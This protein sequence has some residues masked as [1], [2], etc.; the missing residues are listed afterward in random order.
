MIMQRKKL[1]LSA[2]L[3]FLSLMLLFAVL[4]AEKINAWLDYVLFILRPVLI[5]LVLAYICN[6][7]FRLFE[8]K[9]FFGVHPHKLRRILSLVVTY[10]ILLLILTTLVM[11]IVPQLIGSVLDFFNSYESYLKNALVSIN[12]LINYANT[13]FST[14][15]APLVYEDIN[16]SITDFIAGLDLQN[17]IQYKLALL[18]KI[19]NGKFIPLSVLYFS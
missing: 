6:P 5:G 2:S 19:S 15:I 11:L 13:N 18:K 1:F 14:Q 12:D 17:L 8:R 7:I 10:L 16:R 9:L 4:H 3:F